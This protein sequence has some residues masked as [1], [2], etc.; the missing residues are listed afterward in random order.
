MARQDIDGERKALL[1]PSGAAHYSFSGLLRRSEWAAFKDADKGILVTMRAL[2]GAC[3]HI[4]SLNGQFPPIGTR[5]PR[6]LLEN[7][8]GQRT[9]GIAMDAMLGEYAAT[10]KS[11]REA[12]KALKVIKAA[13]L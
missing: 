11:E 12:L 3:L 2:N 7:R 1:V 10:R 8:S 5:I 4:Q 6:K 9:N 13:I